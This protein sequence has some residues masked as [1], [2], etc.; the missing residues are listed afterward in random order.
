LAAVLAEHDLLKQ[1]APVLGVVWDGLGYGDDGQIWGS[2]FFIFENQSFNRLHH[3]SYYP[4]I[5]NNRMAT[6]TSVATYAAMWPDNPGKVWLRKRFTEAEQELFPQLA[7][8]SKQYTS[9]MGR[10][11]DAAAGL[12][13]CKKR[14]TYEGEAAMALQVLAEKSKLT[15]WNP[16]CIALIDNTFN[17]HYL[18]MKMDFDKKN[19]VP[20]EDIALRFHQT[21]VQYIALI[22]DY[23][24]SQKIAF[25]GGVFQNTLLVDLIIDRMGA[26]H[27]LYFHEELPPNDE[28]I[29][30]GQIACTALN[31]SQN[32]VE[33]HIEPEKEILCV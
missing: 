20:K 30:I 31:E 26:Y 16:Y 21:L 1:K 23:N 27:E 33:V 12:L 9:S 17:V 3:L 18:L 8:N 2:E 7:E 22:A 15:V 25:S 28:C 6:E 32:R 19:Q 24:S 10:F 4:V 13:N 29:A 11:F 5:A 14:N